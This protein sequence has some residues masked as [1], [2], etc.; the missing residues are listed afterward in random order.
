MKTDPNIT[1]GLIGGIGAV[2]KGTKARHKLRTIIINMVIG[3]L[4]AYFSMDLVPKLVDDISDRTSMLV[5][6]SI[7]YLSNEFT[8]KLEVV[9]DVVFEVATDKV[10]RIFK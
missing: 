6:F 9:L 8:D 5:S 10:K 1:A 7:G 2:L 4:L 3:G